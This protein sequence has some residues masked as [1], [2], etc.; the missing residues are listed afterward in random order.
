[1]TGIALNEDNSVFYLTRSPE[2]LTLEGVDAWLDNYTG[3]QVRELLLCP[4]SMRSSVASQV[5]QAV[6][7]GFDPSQDNTQPFLAGMRDQPWHWPSGA[8]AHMRHWVSNTLLL[9]QRGIDPYARWIARGR[10]GGLSPWI[11][12]R[13]N[14]VHYVDQPEHPIH[15][16]FWREHPE[17][18]RVPWQ[19]EPSTFQA[20]ARFLRW[21]DRAFDYGQP[22]VRAYQ[23]AYIR[24]LVERYDMDGFEMDWM[25]F[26]FL[27]RPG[28]EEEGA[29][30]LTAFIVEVRDL[31][32]AREKEVGHPIRLGARVPARPETARNLGMDV[33]AWARRGLI[34][35]LVVTPFLYI[36][37][38]MPIELWKRLLDGTGVMLAAGLEAYC[39]AYPASPVNANSIES[40][41]G[42]SSAM[43]DR[44]ADRVY[45]F[46]YFDRQ[47]GRPTTAQSQAAYRQLV[48]EVG[49]LATM[50]GKS[51]RHIV[52]YADHC[53][54]GE[55]QAAAL[56]CSCAPQRSVD[57]RVPIGPT[58]LSDQSGQVRLALEHAEGAAAGTL[59][60]RVN[61]DLCS[62]AKEATL[63]SGWPEPP[64]VY[65]LPAGTLHRG[66]NVVEVL[67][68]LGAEIRLTWVELAISARGGAWPQSAVETQPLWSR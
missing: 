17:Y 37:F 15:D 31:L 56:P 42:A 39:R 65:D 4:N 43:L 27:F 5:R 8:R 63:P 2:E 1:M 40:V 51:R 60:V 57:F 66:C 47:P 32:D 30:I 19:D 50:A 33:V 61:G 7:D 26:G 6:W 16:R 3:T 35:M 64:H 67:N 62:I 48:R 11:S 18:R 55:A 20:P 59:L 58:P 29:D 13:M 23:M 22:E 41:R 24:E 28:F 34:D 36:D 45:L 9:H 49:S 44:G 38:D 52:T 53:A 21:A 54:P 68:G 46:N 25:R 12:M 10:A 14:D